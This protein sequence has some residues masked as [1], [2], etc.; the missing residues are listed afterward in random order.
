MCEGAATEKPGTEA[1]RGDS[2]PSAWAVTTL[3]RSST[4]QLLCTFGVYLRHRITES[5]L[6]EMALEHK[7]PR[8]PL[9]V[10]LRKYPVAVLRCMSWVLVSGATGY[11]VNGYGVSFAVA[12]T[13]ASSATVLTLLDIALLVDLAAILVVGRLMDRHRRVVLITVALFQIPVAVLLFPLLSMGTLVA[14]GLA[15]GLVFL[16]V[17]MIECPPRRAAE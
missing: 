7:P 10:V 11:I 4:H 14:T 6:F 13:G 2:R 9:F 15:F 5:P 12:K 3:S 8:V 17:G 1:Y 16:G